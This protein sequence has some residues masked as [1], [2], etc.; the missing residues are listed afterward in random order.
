M[1]KIVNG[2]TVPL[3]DAEILN[4]KKRDEAHALKMAKAEKV[5]YRA[6]RSTE[7]PKVEELIVAL[8]EARV[9]NDTTALEAIQAKRLAIKK[10][11]PKGGEK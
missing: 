5:A 4:L 8:W 7:Y 9:E 6:K 3:S 2:K 1:Q 11:Y 10:K